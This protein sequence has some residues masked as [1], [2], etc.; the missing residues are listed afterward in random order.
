MT[1]PALEE[2][3]GRLY[4]DPG[5]QTRFHAN[6]ESEARLAGLSEEDCGALMS[7]DWAAFKMSCRVFQHKREQK[8]KGAKSRVWRTW[9][10]VRHIIGLDRR[11][12]RSIEV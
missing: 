1:S 2:F 4:A 10:R 6:P 7:M 8:A 9:R 3:L 12:R 5:V 11:V